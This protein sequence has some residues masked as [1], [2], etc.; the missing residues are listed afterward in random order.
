MT[1]V[2]EAIRSDACFSCLLFP[3]FSSEEPCS[4]DIQ[5]WQNQWCQLQPV[6][7]VYRS[8]CMLVNKGSQ[9]PCL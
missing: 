1:L 5:Q 4:A 9:I 6:Q 8:R 3:S 7:P 2:T